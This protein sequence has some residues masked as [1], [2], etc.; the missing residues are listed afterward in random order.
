MGSDR[1]VV[2]F[3]GRRLDQV[4]AEVYGT[5]HLAWWLALANPRQVFVWIFEED[6]VLRAPEPP[7][8]GFGG[9]ELPPWRR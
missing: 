1:Y 4:S 3:A 9:S 8:D 2:A 6:T 5:P 7:A